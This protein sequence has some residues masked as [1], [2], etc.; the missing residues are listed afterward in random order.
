[1]ILETGSEYL[2]M[3]LRRR[4]AEKKVSSADL[5]VY[6]IRE[7]EHEEAFIEEIRMDDTG[8]FIEAPEEFLSFF[9]AD[10][11][12]LMVWEEITRSV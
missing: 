10:F 2:L 4:I 1:M 11:E 12:D 5:S 7:S 6:F 8:E 9:S 3:R